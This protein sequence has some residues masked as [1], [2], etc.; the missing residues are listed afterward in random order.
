MTPTNQKAGI[1]A[2][3]PMDDAATMS[4]ALLVVE[5]RIRRAALAKRE[6]DADAVAPKRRLSLK[7]WRS[8]ALRQAGGDVAPIERLRNVLETRGAQCP[9]VVS[10]IHAIG[11]S[12]REHEI[13]G[14]ATEL[15]PATATW[16]ADR[17]AAEREIVL[18]GTGANLWH[19]IVIAIDELAV[20]H[21][22]A[23]GDVDDPDAEERQRRAPQ[24]RAEAALRDVEA[25][26][27]PL[28]VG[29]AYDRGLELEPIAGLARRIVDHG[30]RPPAT[31]DA[32]PV[33]GEVAFLGARR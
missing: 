19:A 24:D 8:G 28:L 6:A 11:S 33:G 25:I 10:Y 3:S 15:A 7:A 27:M 26:P 18:T 20:T 29:C 1:A 4:A 32:D 23:F 13:R 2:I 21:P 17:E 12:I 30:M 5:Q 9:R 22:A 31:R 14:I 16:R